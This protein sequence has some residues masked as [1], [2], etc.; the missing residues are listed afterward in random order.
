MKKKAY[1]SRTLKETVGRYV[2][3]VAIVTFQKIKNEHLKN[4]CV[5]EAYAASYCSNSRGVGI[6]IN[7]TTPVFP[8]IPAHGTRRPFSNVELYFTW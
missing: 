5:G 2:F 7:K 3:V 6:L 4:S 8:F 1:G